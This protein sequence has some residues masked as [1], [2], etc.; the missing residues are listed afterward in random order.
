MLASRRASLCLA[1][2]SLASACVRKDAPRDGMAPGPSVAQASAAMVAPPDVWPG[3]AEASGAVGAAFDGLAPLDASVAHGDATARLDASTLAQL[4]GDAGADGGIALP[5]RY[6]VVL[7]AGDS[8]VGGYGGLTKALEEKF[9]RAG[10]RFLSDSWVSAS[11]VT[12]DRQLRFRDLY[13]K[14]RPD[15][16][17]ITLGANDVFVP[18]P[19]AFAWNVASTVKRLGATDCY[20]IGPPTWRKD[21]GIV[22][23]IRENCAP[24]KFFDSSDMSIARTRD[25]I[26]PTNKGGAEWA[27]RFWAFFLEEEQKKGNAG[28]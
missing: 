27:E 7:H 4:I 12:F 21:T 15:L 14:N 6:R 17:I 1:I 9:K 22:A 16:V 8:M 3:V 26:H 19:Q 2:A 13:K 18:S 24:C 25:G 10:A 11:V 20:W 5:R 28:E 23:V